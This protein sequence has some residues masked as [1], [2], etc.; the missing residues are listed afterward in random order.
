[1][2]T[3]ARTDIGT[4]LHVGLLNTLPGHTVKYC[5]ARFHFFYLQVVLEL[6]ITYF[7]E[8]KKQSAPNVLLVRC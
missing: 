3:K 1:M 6:T 5:V 8:S 2:K 4:S 7:N